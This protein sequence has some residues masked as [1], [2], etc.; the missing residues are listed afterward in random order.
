MGIG[1]DIF[2]GDYLAV[3]EALPSLYCLLGHFPA[4][5]IYRGTLRLIL[6]IEAL[7]SWNC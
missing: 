4:G 6:F 5:I 2:Y 3:Y 7:S 1:T